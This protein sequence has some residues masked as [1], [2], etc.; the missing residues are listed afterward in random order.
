MDSPSDE[1]IYDENGNPAER[2]YSNNLGL[3]K[4]RDYAVRFGLDTVSGIE[5]P[6]TEP[7]ISDEDSVR[8][9]MGQGTNNY[10]T[11][12]LARYISAVANRGTVYDLTLLDRVETVDGKVKMQ[13]K[14]KIKNTVEGISQNTW[15][16]VHA[17]MRGVVE[18]NH[19]VFG[20]LNI[21]EIQLF[22]KTGTAQQS[23]SHPDH[24]LFVGFA[25]SSN[26]ELAMAIRIANGYSSTFAA[27]VGNDVMEYYYEITA[28]EELI[29]GTAK[30]VTVSA[31]SD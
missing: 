17:G 1:I 12:Q 25:P 29:T 13:Q 21:S 22:G 15:D 9:S 19:T 26:P 10:T 31:H 30:K 14:P 5:V 16:L 4:L 7:Q 3:D 20:K 28:P 18:N 27:E 23:T 2:E 6:E 8:S 24:G 11:S